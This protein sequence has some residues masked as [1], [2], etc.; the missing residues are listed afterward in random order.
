MG[1]ERRLGAC[2]ET[3]CCYVAD[4]KFT[5][6]TGLALNLQVTLFLPHDCW[7]D[8]YVT[9]AGCRIL[10][11]A[12]M[13]GQ[14]QSLRFQSLL[15]SVL[16]DRSWVTTSEKFCNGCRVIKRHRS[17]LHCSQVLA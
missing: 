15:Y 11:H 16:N 1:L 5:M 10:F 3:Y 12:D 6:Y 8:R 7:G 13:I 14:Q 4:L 9:T 17:V 2:F